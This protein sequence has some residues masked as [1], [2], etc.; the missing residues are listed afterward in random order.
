MPFT[1]ETY[2]VLIAS[3]S[4]LSEECQCAVAAINEW[5]AQHAAAEGA[6][7]LPIMWDTRATPEVGIRRQE[8]TN[9]TLVA[10]SDTLVGLFS[11]KLGTSTSTS[12]AESDVVKEINQFVAAE[13]PTLLY[14]SYRPSIQA[15]ST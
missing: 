8:A 14:F 4:D 6:V 15:A 11:T 2:R 9:R 10:D 7:L 1:A 5:N 12:M 3:P 13:K